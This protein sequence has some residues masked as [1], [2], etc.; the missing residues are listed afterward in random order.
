MADDN[1]EAKVTVQIPQADIMSA[2]LKQLLDSFDSHRSEMQTAFK[3]LS[4]NVELVSNDIGVVKER[5]TILESWRSDQDVRITRASDGLRQ[6]SQ[7]DMAQEALLAEE[8][9][10]REA[11]AKQVETLSATNETQLA[12]LSRLDKIASNP[13]IK[14][15]ATVAA[16]ALTTWAASKGMK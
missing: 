10:A 5:I 9:T 6:A 7:A 16:T 11:L 13:T 12:I 3:N 1:P 14:I 4:A 15:I 8:R 2:R